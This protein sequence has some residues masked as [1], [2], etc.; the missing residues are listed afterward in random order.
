[1]DNSNCDIKNI[2]DI[3][4]FA[5][6]L[7]DRYYKD[8]KKAFAILRPHS[9]AVMRKAWH[10]ARHCE[11]SVDGR[12]IIEAALLHDIGAFR[13]NA[14]GIGCYGDEPYLRHGVIGRSILE[15]EGLPRHA[16]VCERHIGVGLTKTDIIRNNLPLPHRDMVPVS[17]EEK[18]IC[19]S[20]L[21]F[22]KTHPEHERSVREVKNSVQKYGKNKVDIFENWLTEYCFSNY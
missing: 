18:I 10:I 7:L 21:F 2:K 22:N 16:L 15:N 8:Y 5:L 20:D 17:H 9:E 3:K 12:L 6:A 19:L 1:M 11:Q 4:D 13:T 14:P